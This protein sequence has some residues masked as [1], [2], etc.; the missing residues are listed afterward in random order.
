M[1][2][3]IVVAAAFVAG[4]LGGHAPLARSQ[5]TNPAVV[6]EWN[7]VLQQT[8]P[9][10]LGPLG[11]RVYTMMHIAMFDAANSIEREYTPFRVEMSASSGASP[12]AAAA[13]AAH[14][15]LVALI[16]ASAGQYH[17]LLQSRLAALPPGRAAQGV[18]IGKAVA[19]NILAWRN[20]DGSAGP[21]SSYVLPV[22]PG[23]WQP[24]GAPAGLTQLPRM[25]PFTLSTATQYLAPRFPEMDSARYAADYDEVKS[26]GAVNSATRTPAQT[27]LAQL[28]AAVTITGTNINV[29]WNN[30]VRDVTLANHLT[31]LQS[32][33]LYALM[34]VATIDGLQTSQTGKFIYGLW[35]PVT[36]I[37]NADT[38]PNPATVGDAA[39]A[40][41]L[42]TPPYPTYPGNM[43]CIG[44]AAAR[45]IELGTGTDAFSFTATW[46]GLNGGPDIQRSYAAFS[47]LAQDEADSR[48]YGGIH[49]RFDNEASQPACRKVAEHVFA[50]VMRP[51]TG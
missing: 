2:S 39:W 24:T 45:A 18:A 21:T 31:L 42:A 15:V 23:L 14:D 11:V 47:Q 37:R 44:A 17:S 50:K 19:A 32:A 13:Q 12:E 34:N 6:I 38:D 35:R 48:I 26:V 30:V 36:A 10:A 7:Q 3:Q 49:F 20:N 33:R 46:R 29:I 16:P 51:R 25:L 5:D 1:K 41:L 9:A 22:V 28:F 40:P 4:M 27:Q 8:V 43:A